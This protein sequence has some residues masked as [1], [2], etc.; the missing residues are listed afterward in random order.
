MSDRWQFSLSS[1]MLFMT[2]FA[3]WLSEMTLSV[4]T[5][6]SQEDPSD[7]TR[8]LLRPDFLICWGIGTLVVVCAF[9]LIARK[10][11]VAVL[12]GLVLIVASV[13]IFCLPNVITMFEFMNGI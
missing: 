11:S 6:F 7:A 13:P 12:L 9:L 4:R 10:T 5:L 8:E 3:V 2:A 1:L